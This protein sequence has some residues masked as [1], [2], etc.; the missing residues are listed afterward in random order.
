MG[1]D[2][3][4]LN[5]YLAFLEHDDVNVI[6]IDWE[7]VAKLDYEEAASRVKQLG[8]YIAKMIEFLESIGSDVNNMTMAGFSLGA[9]LVGSAGF[10]T[11]NKIGY[12]AGKCDKNYY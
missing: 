10:Q 4:I 2:F 8:G 9:Q 3:L 5:F 1:N 7:I 12:I 11:K 6:V